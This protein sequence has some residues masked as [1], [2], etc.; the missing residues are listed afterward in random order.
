M[1]SPAPIGLCAVFVG[2][3]GR[4]MGGVAK[5]LLLLDG[6]RIID[7]Q[8]ALLSAIHPSIVL[9]GQH[10][11]YNDLG[12][13]QVP[14]AMPGGGPLAGLV[15]LL[16]EAQRRGAEEVLA[17]ACDLPYVTPT[18]LASLCAVAREGADAVMARR[19]VTKPGPHGAETLAVFEP[20]CARYAVSFCPRL[21]AAM[22][23]GQLRLQA[24]LAQS[25]VKEWHPTSDD[26]QALIDWDEPADCRAVI[27]S[28]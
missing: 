9:V 22:S 26:A 24:V 23:A 21:E 5:G 16:R 10:P 11:A 12:L 17:L 19:V 27:A 15:A 3:A 2:G 18:A 13:V 25:H 6:T 1:A 14:D 20:L 28:P 8:I 4:R 7:R